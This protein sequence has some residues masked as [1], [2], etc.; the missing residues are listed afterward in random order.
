[1]M[2]NRWDEDTARKIIKN[3]RVKEWGYAIG[4]VIFLFIAIIKANIFD[5]SVIL[6]V[7]AVSFIICSNIA[8]YHLVAFKQR[9]RLTLNL[10][11]LQN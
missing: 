4:G 6:V 2:Q 9:R 11:S 3:Y 10:C 8:S 1:M 5:N 7:I